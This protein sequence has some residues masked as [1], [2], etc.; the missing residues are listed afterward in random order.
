[1]ASKKKVIKPK[2]TAT[3]V[4]RTIAVPRGTTEILVRIQIG[5]ARTK[6]LKMSKSPIDE[7]P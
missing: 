6:H 4:R 1:M 5:S 7:D 2:A 3:V